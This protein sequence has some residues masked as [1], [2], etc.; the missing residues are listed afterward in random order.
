MTT[1]AMTI[2][3]LASAAGVHVE[4]V[5]YYQRRGLLQEPERPQGSVRRYGADDVGR[6]QFIRRAQA[7]GF[8]LDE[9]AGLLEV[10]G[11]RTCEQTRLLT[12]R[13]LTEVRQRMEELRLLEAELEQLVDEC[14]HVATGEACP[15]LDRLAQNIR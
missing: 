13:K 12:E 4:T 8:R 14:N 9:I 10:K 11:Q 5:R 15:A 7:V 3:R 2:S 6:L 1:N